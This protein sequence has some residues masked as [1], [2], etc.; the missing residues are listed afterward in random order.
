M[1]NI[2]LHKSHLP[3]RKSM[4]CI[5]NMFKLNCKLNTLHYKLNIYFLIYNTLLYTDKHIFHLTYMC[6]THI[7]HIIWA[8]SIFYNY[9]C[10]LYNYYFNLLFNYLYTLKNNYFLFYHKWFST[11]HINFQQHICSTFS[12]MENNWIH[13][14]SYSSF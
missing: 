13:L 14:L 7:H 5:F 9:K 3:S 10:S 11:L 8:K 4:D 6:S 12:C 1:I 2:F